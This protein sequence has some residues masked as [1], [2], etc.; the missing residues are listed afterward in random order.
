MQSPQL[1]NQGYHNV[2]PSQGFHTHFRGQRRNNDQQHK[3]KDNHSSLILYVVNK[4]QTQC[5]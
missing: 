5:S 4:D 3:T 2:F 1:T